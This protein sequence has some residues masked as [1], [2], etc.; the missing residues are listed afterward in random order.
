MMPIPVSTAWLGTNHQSEETPDCRPQLYLPGSLPQRRQSGPAMPLGPNPKPS[1][2]F[3]ASVSR[4]LAPKLS[5]LVTPEP[6]RRTLCA[7]WE[8]TMLFGAAQN[9]QSRKNL[10]ALLRPP[11]C[12]AWPLSIIPDSNEMPD[13]TLKKDPQGACS[14]PAKWVCHVPRP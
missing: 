14:A 5:I 7:I 9:P 1:L 4:V 6:H 8:E 11:P 13:H 3:Q 12:I 10:R 2:G